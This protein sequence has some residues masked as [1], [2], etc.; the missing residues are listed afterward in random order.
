VIC[1]RCGER[2]VTT[3][4]DLAPMGRGG[5][6]WVVCSECCCQLIAANLPD[7]LSSFRE[8]LESGMTLQQALAELKKDAESA[9]P[10]SQ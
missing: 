5:K 2:E 7:E 3:S 4:L 1:E 8:M 9:P 10:D 6:H